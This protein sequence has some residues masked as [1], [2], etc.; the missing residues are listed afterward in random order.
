MPLQKSNSLPPDKECKSKVAEVELHTI[1]PSS[2]YWFS[3][4][5]SKQYCSEN[6]VEISDWTKSTDQLAELNYHVTVV[7]SKMNCEE[8]DVGE[9]GVMAHP[10]YAENVQSVHGKKGIREM[11]KSQIGIEGLGI[12]RKN[13]RGDPDSLASG[14][15]GY[16][17]ATSVNTKEQILDYNDI[18]NG[19]RILN[20]AQFHSGSYCQET[21]SESVNYKQELNGTQLV[22]C[23]GSGSVRFTDNI[24]DEVGVDQ[25]LE[26]RSSSSL[27]SDSLAEYSGLYR[28]SSVTDN[29]IQARDYYSEIKNARNSS[30]DKIS[31]YEMDIQN[32]YNSV[33]EDSHFVSK[34]SDVLVHCERTHSSIT[35]CDD[36]D[37]FLMCSDAVHENTILHADNS[38]SSNMHDVT[39]LSNSLSSTKHVEGSEDRLCSQS[40]CVTDECHNEDE[41]NECQ[42]QEEQNRTNRTIMRGNLIPDVLIISD[43]DPITEVMA[44]SAQIDCSSKSM[45]VD[46]SVLDEEKSLQLKGEGVSFDTSGPDVIEQSGEKHKSSSSSSLLPVNLNPDECTWDMLFDDDGECLD[47]KLMEEVSINY[48]Y[49]TSFSWQYAAYSI[50]APD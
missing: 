27:S 8:T 13:K 49:P 42:V 28:P 29:G 48:L 35:T 6:N 10:F 41:D 17:T 34:C 43:P 5:S 19:A 2:D 46:D 21:N 25:G 18:K 14:Q 15:S 26:R 47:P 1:L 50:L 31:G 3:T 36:G 44:P 12:G 7:G 4:P 20:K 24:M 39:N 11:E 30:Q 23:E 40:L 37:Q 9:G 45:S 32:P 38:H 22:H 16:S 33:S